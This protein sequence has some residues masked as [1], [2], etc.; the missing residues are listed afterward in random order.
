MQKVNTSERA[1]IAI[2]VGNG[3]LQVSG[4]R[5]KALSDEGLYLLC[6]FNPKTFPPQTQQGLWIFEGRAQTR[7]KYAGGRAAFPLFVG[8]WRRPTDAE[9]I[10]LAAGEP[11]WEK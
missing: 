8:T 3:V 9:V 6:L 7:P 11:L 1:A 4:R 5:I 2:G 10:K